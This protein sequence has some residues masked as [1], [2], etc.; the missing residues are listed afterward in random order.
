MRSGDVSSS[1]ARLT[2]P[3]EVACARVGAAGGE[4]EEVEVASVVLPGEKNG[5]LVTSRRRGDGILAAQRM[6]PPPVHR[7]RESL[8]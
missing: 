8:A 1:P 2:S 6:L 3:P 7:P 5:G 4:D